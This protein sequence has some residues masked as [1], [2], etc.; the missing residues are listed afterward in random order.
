MKSTDIIIN[1]LKSSTITEFLQQNENT[2]TGQI[3]IVLQFES[4]DGSGFQLLVSLKKLFQS[5][6][7]SFQ[8]SSNKPMLD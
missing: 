7:S 6:G 1:E 8:I 3:P 4:I 5:T 2:L